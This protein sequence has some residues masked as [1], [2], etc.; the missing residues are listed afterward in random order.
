[1]NTVGRCKQGIRFCYERYVPE[2]RIQI[3]SYRRDLGYHPTALIDGTHR[4]Y[5]TPIY[6]AA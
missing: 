5:I 6:L 1:M 4:I 2:A 3:T